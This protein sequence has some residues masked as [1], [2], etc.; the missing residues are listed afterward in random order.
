M[1]RDRK[2]ARERER[3]R[4]AEYYIKH[5]PRL[6]AKQALY[7]RNNPKQVAESKKRWAL[8]NPEKLIAARKRY[9]PKEKIFK[10]KY[11][12]E[13]REEILAKNKLWKILNPERCKETAKAWVIA[14]RDRVR[15][16][17]RK[18]NAKAYAENPEKFRS[19]V[20]KSA[21]KA[22]EML[23]PAYIRQVAKQRSGKMPFSND[24]EL[25]L[26]S[27]SLHR[28]RKDL[29]LMNAASAIQKYAKHARRN[30]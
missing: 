17:K 15:K 1:T 6:L 24:P 12:A 2:Q 20:R 23:K 27:I 21:Q 29:A 8:K 19:R 26:R 14:N 10:R 30:N 16:M 28:A 11:Y 9:R 25:V 5:R 7:R 18:S 4:Q 22:R 3:V 13:H